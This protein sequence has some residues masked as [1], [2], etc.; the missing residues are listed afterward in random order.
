MFSKHRDISFAIYLK[1]WCYAFLCCILSFNCQARM[2]PSKNGQYVFQSNE[3]GKN[4]EIISFKYV[5]YFSVSCASVVQ[6]HISRK[7]SAIP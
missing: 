4:Q 7:S 1:C 5:I 3:Q 2:A 6:A